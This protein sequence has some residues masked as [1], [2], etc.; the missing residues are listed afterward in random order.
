MPTP[1]DLP[2][3]PA[4]RPVR[5]TVH[6][7][8]TFDTQG[9]P[10]IIADTGQAFALSPQGCIEEVQG[11]VDYFYHCG[12]DA[13]QPL[14]SQCAECGRIS[15]LRC[16]CSCANC[17]KPICLEHVKTCEPE[18][19]RQV[20]LCENCYSVFRR[21]CVIRAIARGLLSPFVS[22]SEPEGR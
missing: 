19:G 10:I 8:F 7:R 21:R 15:C 20:R 12:H 3:D 18:P 14:G 16:S 9:K 2:F 17:F 5:R 13:H 4:S 22:F 1:F 11:T 6:L